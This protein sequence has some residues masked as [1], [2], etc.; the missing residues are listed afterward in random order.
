[1]GSSVSLAH[2][3]EVV[4]ASTV[5]ALLAINWALAWGG[6]SHIFCIVE[7]CEDILVDGGY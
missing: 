7:G 2:G 6:S 5:I 3:S 1:M 4:L